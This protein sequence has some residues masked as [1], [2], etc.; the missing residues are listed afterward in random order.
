MAQYYYFNIH[1]FNENLVE[2]LKGNSR[3]NFA[4]SHNN[5]YLVSFTKEHAIRGVLVKVL[6]VKENTID[7]RFEINHIYLTTNLQVAAV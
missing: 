4:T 7:L 5:L 1:I 3:H 2:Q 6:R